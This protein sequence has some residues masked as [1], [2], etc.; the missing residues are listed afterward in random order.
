MKYLISILCL[1]LIS[2]SNRQKKNEINGLTIDP[3]IK[4]EV[5]KYIIDQAE[6]ESFSKLMQVYGNSL[7]LESYE[8][9]SLIV[10]TTDFSRKLPFKSFYLWNK[11][12]LGINGAYGLFGG[13]GFYVKITDKKAELFH[14]LSSDDFPTYAYKKNDSLIMRLEVPC[15][16]TKIVLSEIPDS[17]KNQLIYGLVEF[18]SNNFYSASGAFREGEEPKK[19]KT[20]NNMKIYFRSGLLKMNE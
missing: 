16:D 9:D 8:N 10:S 20:R 2:C 7:Y 3:N 19:K 17:T 6:F 1:M 5:E 4:S 14:M 12:T 13:T 18:K 11:D 15:T